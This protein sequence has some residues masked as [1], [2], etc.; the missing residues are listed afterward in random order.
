MEVLMENNNNNDNAAD[1]AV[2]GVSNFNGEVGWEGRVVDWGMWRVFTGNSASA[3]HRRFD[4]ILDRC[5]TISLL[6]GKKKK[7]HSN[8]P[9]EKK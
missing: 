3:L 8:F 4:M 9:L 5:V 1:K 6:C 2:W 7:F